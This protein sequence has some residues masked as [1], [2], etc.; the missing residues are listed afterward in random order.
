MVL[1]LDRLAGET[2]YATD[3]IV[4]MCDV[5]AD[6]VAFFRYHDPKAQTFYDYNAEECEFVRA[7]GVFGAQMVAIGAARYRTKGRVERTDPRS[8]HRHLPV[9]FT[10]DL[11]SAIPH[12][13]TA[14]AVEM[15]GEPLPGF[16][17][18]ERA[19]YIFGSE[20]AGIPNEVI[21]ICDHHVSIPAGSL[22][23]AAAVNVVLYDRTSKRSQE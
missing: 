3:C 8:T 1:L 9:I 13:C 17:H 5:T 2:Q 23:L 22:N 15:G 11:L 19:F 4:E 18:P 20:D 12:E 14:V 10:E 21:D 16:E 7:A 6:V